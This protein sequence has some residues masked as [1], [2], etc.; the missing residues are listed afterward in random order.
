MKFQLTPNVGWATLALLLLHPFAQAQV[1][2]PGALPASG[3]DEDTQ[4]LTELS[5]EQLMNIEVTVASRTK[6]KLGDVPAAVYV[7]TGDEIR[8]A[9]HQSIQDALRMVPGFFVSHWT[10]ESWDVTARGFGTGTA[11]TNLAY[12]NQLLVMI[13]G[14]SV[15]SPHF[16]GV[17]WALQ[18]VDLEDIDRIEIIRGPGGIM[19]GSNTLHGI[20]HVITKHASETHGAKFHARVG[21]DDRHYSFRYGTPVGETGHLRLWGK[22]T[23]YDTPENPFAGYRQDWTLNSGGMRMDWTD[24]SE[25]IH[26]VWWRSYSGRFRVIGFELMFFTPYSELN[27]K[28]G[29]QIA[30]SMEDPSDDSRWM[31]SYNK[32][33]Q[34]IPTQLDIDIE[35][36]DAEYQ[37]QIQI[38]DTNN[39]TWGAGFKHIRSDLFGDDPFYHDY[40]PRHITQNN[41]RAFIVDAIDL[42]DTFQLVLGLQ[43]EHNEFTGFELQ[44]SVRGTWKQSSEL[45]VWGAVSRAV[46][47]PSIEEISLSPN[48]ITIG[49]PDF[50]SEDL[51]AF[52]LG[53]RWQPNATTSFD[54]ATFYNEYTD[55][56]MTV[57]N[58]FGQGQI[59]NGAE[60][61]AW[62]GEVAIDLKPS[63]RWSI[64]S[65]YSLYGATIESKATG[66]N[67]GTDNYSPKNQF[68]V[69]SYYDITETVEF[70]A[71][72]YV[73]KTLTDPFDAEY[74]RADARI[75]YRPNNALEIAFGSQ[76]INDPVYS[77]FDSFDNVRRQI[78]IS[79]TWTPGRQDPSDDR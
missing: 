31:V 70:D 30:W 38:S 19:W 44:P 13:D 63:D 58:G 50:Q 15:F 43:A 12:H 23:T 42:S 8:R 32:D 52:E 73:V 4:D 40:D 48:S 33:Q 64:R 39:L 2:S 35:T 65:A 54:V 21:G 61:H 77:E 1:M 16:P 72:V 71:G 17:W 9:G 78:Y 67:L 46:R 18:D 66:A 47:T 57:D 5:L 24:S 27:D 36:L 10:T 29:T 26:N 41:P 74:I 11:L 28:T 6:Q 20:V 51:I 37:R 68:N 69:R 7:I 14:V 55:L 25:R 34:N 75:G 22:A 59:T 76:S 56:Y 60:G 49:D 53:T 79:L 62:G 45:M 3:V